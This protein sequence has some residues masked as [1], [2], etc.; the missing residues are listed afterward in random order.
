MYLQF[1]G[2]F[3][4]GVVADLGHHQGEGHLGLLPHITAAILQA[5]EEVGHDGGELRRKFAGRGEL[6]FQPG[7]ELRV[8]VC[9]YYGLGS[10]AITEYIR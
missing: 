5:G 9:V 7:E 10:I 3:E 8:C 4:H 2:V 6:F 1:A